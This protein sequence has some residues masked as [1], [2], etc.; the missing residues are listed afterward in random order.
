LRR[1][2]DWDFKEFFLNTAGV[3]LIDIK[4]A[5]IKVTPSAKIYEKI[6]A[7]IENPKNKKVE[8]KITLRPGCNTLDKKDCKPISSCAFRL[9]R[10]AV[11]KTVRGMT[12]LNHFKKIT[13]PGSLRKLIAIDSAEKKRIR[14]DRTPNMVRYFVEDLNKKD[15]LSGFFSLNL[16]RYLINPSPIPNVEKT[17]NHPEIITA[18]M[19]N[20]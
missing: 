18:K 5:R 17:M 11:N 9:E 15:S 2:L 8:I 3:F 12:K 16:G 13:N 20:P 7:F 4:Y 19:N 6:T 1:N 10:K 14:L